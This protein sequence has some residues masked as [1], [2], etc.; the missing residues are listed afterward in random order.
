MINSVCKFCGQ[1]KPPK[2]T[3]QIVDEK[4]FSVDWNSETDI[5]SLQAAL[6]IRFRQIKGYRRLSLT[7]LPFKTDK[8]SAF[9][10][11]FA[12]LNTNISSIYSN[13]TLD[14]TKAYYVYAHTNP[15][16]RLSTRKPLDAFAATLGLEYRPFYIGKGK[17]NRDLQI[18]RNETHRKTLQRI[19]AMGREVQVTKLK[20]A[21]TE[22]EALQL[23]AKLIDIFWLL[24]SGGYLCNLD[25][26]YAKNE[27]R[28]MYTNKLMSI[29]KTPERE[30]LHRELYEKE[31]V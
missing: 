19:K 24:P 23:E 20:T 14:E 4:L 16:I 31:K 5:K 9:D 17:G 22:S 29:R 7:T 30:R 2:N 12:I 28:K 21:L 3:L 26:G 8:N 6:R 13:L 11:C 15:T 25:E 18:T 1:V 10:S 27:R